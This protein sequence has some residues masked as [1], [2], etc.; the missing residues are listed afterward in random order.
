MER[1]ALQRW[2]PRQMDDR[3]HHVIYRRD[4]ERHVHD[5]CRLDFKADF[6][7][8]PKEVICLAGSG[9]AVPGDPAGPVDV[10]R[11]ASPARLEDH[12]LT[13]PFGLGISKR[14]LEVVNG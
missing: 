6:Q 11:Y 14:V 4:V 1:L 5:G 2:L 9:L 13:D 10:N 7:C 12:L 8:P 3:A